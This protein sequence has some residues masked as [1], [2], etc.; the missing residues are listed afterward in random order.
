[1]CARCYP[2]Y[3]GVDEAFERVQ[4]LLADRG[5]SELDRRALELVLRVARRGRH[6]SSSRMPAV[7]EAV[8]S[9]VR[10]REMLNTGL[11]KIADPVIEEPDPED[12]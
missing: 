6:I 2:V 10:A 12:D 9:F 1:M 5:T 7:N 8:Q 3:V 4:A 11:S